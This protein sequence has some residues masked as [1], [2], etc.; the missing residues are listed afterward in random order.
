[1]SQHDVC[2]KEEIFESTFIECKSCID[3]VIDHH[4]LCAHVSI[5]KYVCVKC[6]E[7][8]NKINSLKDEADETLYNLSYNIKNYSNC[9]DAIKKLGDISIALRQYNRMLLEKQ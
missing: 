1:M 6:Y 2:E 3:N 7:I 8:E 4:C 9:D 5:K